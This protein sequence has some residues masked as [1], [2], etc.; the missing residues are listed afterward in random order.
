M[1]IEHDTKGRIK[2]EKARAQEKYCAKLV[3]TRGRVTSLGARGN[4]L[5]NGLDRINIDSELRQAYTWDV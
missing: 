3:K 4:R 1:A 5:G 2:Q